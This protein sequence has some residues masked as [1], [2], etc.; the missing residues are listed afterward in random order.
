MPATV[1]LS[2]QGAV[3]IEREERRRCIPRGEGL[4][5]D[6][7]TFLRLPVKTFGRFSVRGPAA[8]R[9]DGGTEKNSN[10]MRNGCKALRYK[11]WQIE[12]S[13]KR[14]WND[15]FLVWCLLGGW[16]SFLQMLVIP[17]ED[18]VQTVQQV[19][20]FVKTM[21]LA[22]VDDQLGLDAVALEATVEFLALARRVD[23][24]GVALKNQ[25]WRLH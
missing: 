23:R 21:R 5:S 1:T 15:R 10:T 11:V 13:H 12:Q 8:W 18:A 4:S 17:G 20:F 7:S 25:S 24:I 16:C 6:K 19:F 3:A 22:R 14:D 9:K 2:T